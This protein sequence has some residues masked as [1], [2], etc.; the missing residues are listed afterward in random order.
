[1]I[2]PMPTATDRRTPS[3]TTEETESPSPTATVT[4]VVTTY[5]DDPQI[6]AVKEKIEAMKQPWLAGYRQL[7][8]D[9]TRT[10]GASPLSVVDDGPP[11]DDKKANQFGT[12]CSGDCDS[13]DD[14]K[15]ALRMSRWTRTLAQAYQFSGR[16]EFA[17]GAIELLNHWFVARE[18]RMAPSGKNHGR[19]PFAIELHITI[20]A[21]IYAA[22]LVEAHPYW[23]EVGTNGREAL[24]R[25]IQ[26]YLQDLEDG[27]D[28]EEY[29]GAITNNI[30]AWWL[31]ARGTAAAYLGDQ[32]AFARVVDD[33]KSTA[34]DQVQPDGGLEYEKHREDGLFYSIYG[35]KALFMTA[36]LAR[37]FD[38]DLYGYPS[39]EKPVL[40]RICDYHAPYLLDPSTWEWGLGEE[41]RLTQGE[42]GEAASLYELAYSEWQEESH[43]EVIRSYGRPVYDRR[44]LGWVSLTHG[45]RFSL[46]V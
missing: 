37:Q 15:A 33:W 41:G 2:L 11:T 10:V 6:R 22:G 12:N 32:Q 31:A 17:E 3:T 40:H 5:L 42:F 26:A 18:T 27:S 38:E 34:V 28:E 14:Y 24:R 30:Y 36:E 1:M 35:A 39:D 20:P 25:W 21:M 45:N 9:A 23:D 13:R 16:E 46:D 4:P 43:A 19:T 44:Y 29:T 8:R 7:M